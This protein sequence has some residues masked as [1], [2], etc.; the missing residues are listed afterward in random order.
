MWAH[1]QRE[2]I[3]VARCAVE[4]LMRANGWHGVTRS[5][6]VRTTIPD[7]DAV[8]P[9]DLVDRQFR[10]L[11]PN[12]LVVADFTY[13]RLTCGVFVYTAFVIDAFMS[14]SWAGNA[15]PA[16]MSGFVERAIRKPL[17]SA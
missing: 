2:G 4:R 10:V 15:R 5:K 1:L 3:E 13:V 14:G 11:P 12:M 6:R 8:R 7:P 9:P 16:S 17:P